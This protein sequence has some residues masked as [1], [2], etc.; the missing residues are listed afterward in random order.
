[1][2]I[3]SITPKRMVSRP[4]YASSFYFCRPVMFLDLKLVNHATD[5]NLFT[6]IAIFLMGDS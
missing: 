2:G 4:I 1:M 3:V 5:L 6:M